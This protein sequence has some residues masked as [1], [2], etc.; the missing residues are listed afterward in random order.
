MHREA[1]QKVTQHGMLIK[2]P[3]TG[4]PMQSPYLTIKNKQALI[5]LKAAA[6][7]GFSPVSR[8]S[9]SVDR[10]SSGNPFANNGRR[11]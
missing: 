7:L 6:E 5:M 1:A 3:N 9:V 2:A 8:S 4:V 11:P 10:E